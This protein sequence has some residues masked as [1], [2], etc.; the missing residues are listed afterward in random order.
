MALKMVPV[1]ERSKRRQMVKELSTLFQMLRKKQADLTNVIHH[2]SNSVD[3]FDENDATAIISN[4]PANAGLSTL[5]RAPETET[6]SISSQHNMVSNDSASST[7]SFAGATDTDELNDVFRYRGR[8]DSLMNDDD[9]AVDGV[10][11]S[12]THIVD[13]YDAFANLEDGGVALMME[14]LD[15][16]SLQ[17]IVDAGGCD[18]EATLAN[19]AYQALLGLQFLH[20]CNQIHRD[21]KPGNLLIDHYGVV[22]VSDLGIL[23]QLE[24]SDEQLQLGQGDAS[25]TSPTIGKRDPSPVIPR[26]RTFVGTATYMAPERIDG[27]EYSFGS[28]V[29]SLGLCVLTVALGR[30]PIDTT[31]G[32]WTILHSIRDQPAPTAPTSFSQEFRDFIADCLNHDPSARLTCTQLLRHPFLRKVYPEDI[33]TGQS[34]HRGVAELR[35]ILSAVMTHLEK[36]KADATLNIKPSPVAPTA[37]SSISVVS[38]TSTAAPVA[39][40]SA[41]PQG[42]NGNGNVNVNVN[43]YGIPHLQIALFE[44]TPR[45]QPASSSSVQLQSYVLQA[46]LNKPISE[47]LKMLF[48]GDLSSLSGP[49]NFSLASKRAR[50]KLKPLARQLRIPVRVALQET[51]YYCEEISKCDE[52]DWITT[53]KAAHG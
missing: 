33:S 12:P 48:F 39:T 36:L 22:K 7:T 13:F 29:W 26:A 11:V 35:S 43:A 30:L 21:I 31:G 27:R 44:P 1:F 15:G 23:K 50:Q 19:I 14:Y 32:Y 41:H 52:N 38:V 2:S 20:S 25:S 24:T 46:L 5:D 34:Q 8:Q 28:D 51:Y 37:S 49:L 17:D 3:T 45:E 40:N 18:D 9:D 16:G 4:R 47:V 42:G 53:P 10:S 6:V